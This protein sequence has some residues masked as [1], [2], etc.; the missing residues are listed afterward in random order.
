M[1]A[2][3]NRHTSMGRR[4]IADALS[5]TVVALNAIVFAELCVGKDPSYIEDQLI[6]TRFEDNRYPGCDLLQS[7]AA[8][9][10]DI[11]RAEASAAEKRH[12]PL[13]D[14]FIGAHAELMGWPLATR[15]KER[16]RRYFP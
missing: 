16:Y 6:A 3:A 9:I 11:E 1:R 2:S 4:V 8:H 14:F 12:F 13:P 5:T 10:L 7:V 15:D